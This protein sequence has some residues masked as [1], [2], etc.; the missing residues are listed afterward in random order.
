[1]VPSAQAAVGTVYGPY[2]VT[3]V[4]GTGSLTIT[5]AGVH[6]VTGVTGTGTIVVQSGI[7]G[8]VVV[9]LAGATRTT[10]TSPLQINGSS[11]VLYLADNPTNTLT[12][13]GSRCRL[14]WND[15]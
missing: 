4:V 6:E 7:V 8:Q 1:M 5:T 9:V 13:I 15:V 11:V 3:N 14:C 12:C 2:T 10:A